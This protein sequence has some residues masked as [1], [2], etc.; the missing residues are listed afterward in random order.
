MRDNNSHIDK[1]FGRANEAPRLLLVINA[2][3]AL[4]YLYA[5]VFWF[6]KGELYLYWILIVGQV[7]HTWQVLSFI[8][9]IWDTGYTASGNRTHTPPADV[10]ITVC[11]EPAEIVEETIR[12]A[13]AMNYPYFTVYVLNDGFVAGK[14]NWRQIEALAKSLGVVCI[15][16]RKPGG[17]KAGNINHALNHTSNPFVVLFDADHIPQTN[18]LREVMYYFSDEKVGFVQTPQY[19]RNHKLNYVTAGAWEQ[20]HLFYGP[21]LKG[22]N[23][24]NAVSMCG[25]NMAIR[26]EALLEVGGMCDTNIAEDFVTG[27]FIHEHGWKSVYVPKLLTRGLAPFDFLSYYK[28]QYRWARGSLEILF[29]FNPFFKRT[30][31]WAQKIQYLA[32]ASYYLSGLIVFIYAIV[33]LVFLFTGLVPFTTSTMGLALVFLPYI[34]LTLYSLQTV[35]NY[36]YTFRALAFSIG[37]FPIHLKALGA[38]L[39]GL[40]SSFEV[41]SKRALQGNFIHLVTPHLVYIILVIIGI[42]VALFREGMTP[43]FS[44]NLAWSL[45]NIATFLPFIRAVVPHLALRTRPLAE[46][47]TVPEIVK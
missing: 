11:G 36:T 22:K 41:T 19:Y 46:D 8:Y 9:T 6:S 12:A 28:Q 37:A 34:F 31:T 42:V 2:V 4:L 14:E 1:I 40:R 44:T 18:F 39:L 20:Q 26:R 7:F 24:M 3:M 33:P 35:S 30:L 15:T 29:K 13:L 25:T 47:E 10:F 45:F 17:A 23:R 5:L 32:S 16:R 38:V 21:I 27:L 43:S